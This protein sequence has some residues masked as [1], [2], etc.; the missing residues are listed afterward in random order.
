MSLTYSRHTRKTPTKRGKT[1]EEV[2]HIKKYIRVHLTH[3]SLQFVG[4]LG[5]RETKRTIET[6]KNT[7][8]KS[9]EIK[10]RTRKVINQQRY[11]PVSA[12]IFN[13]DTFET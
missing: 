6:E 12:P 8:T 2:M 13:S 3:R 1:K 9:R 11:S 5:Q 7:Q 10:L 4:L